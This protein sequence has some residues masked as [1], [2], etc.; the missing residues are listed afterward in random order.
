MVSK[1]LS[2][3]RSVSPFAVSSG[4]RLIMAAAAILLVCAACTLNIYSNRK[5]ARRHAAQ[6]EM[7]IAISIQGDVTRV[8]DELDRSIQSALR[9]MAAPGFGEMDA[10]LR[11]AVLFDG[12]L[13]VEGEVGTALIAD[14]S[15]QTIYDS[16]GVF[17]RKINVYDRDYFQAQMRQPDLGLFISRPVLSRIDQQ[18]VLV[19]VRRVNH[20]DGSFAGVVAVGLRLR[21]FQNLFAQLDI[22][23]QG[24]I[25]LI[26]AD[27]HLIARRPFREGDINRDMSRSDLFRHLSTDSSG[28]FDAVGSFDGLDRLYS[29]RKFENLPFVVCVGLP[30]REVYAE[31]LQSS[32][33]LGFVL[34]LLLAFTGSSLAWALWCELSRRGR[35]E[36]AARRLEHKYIDARAR[37]D[38]LFANS[39]DMMVVARSIAQGN[40]VF[41]AVNP[42]WEH[43]AG[44]PAKA[45]L[46]RCVHTCMSSE[47]A[48]CLL[49]AWEVCQRQ[50]RPLKRTF[51]TGDGRAKRSWEASIAPVFS[52]DG[53][54]HR[55]V[56][57][58]RDMTERQ[59]LEASL[60]QSQRM[61]AM[62]QLTAGVAHDFNNLLQGIIG[63]LE[64]LSEQP[65]PTQESR[66]YI[67]VARDAAESGANLVHRLLAFARKQPLQP[68]VL[69]P[70]QIVS[71]MS[72]LLRHTLGAR[73][74]LE[75]EIAEAPWAVRADGPQLQNCL[76]NLAINARDAMQAG[77]V[78]RLSV[79]NVDAETAKAAGL[80]SGEYT[81]FAVAD[82]GEGMSPETLE[83]ALEPFFTTKEE[84]KGT[85]LGLPMV[86]GFARQSGGDLRIESA[87]GQGTTVRLWLPRATETECDV[88]EA[89]SAVQLRAS[90]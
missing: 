84:G 10:V 1:N 50:R 54:I 61:E 46:G 7:N 63:A 8:I 15:G 5:S 24:T 89:D 16:R 30:E 45:A 73:I 42:V 31:W 21:Y 60:R 55:V 52:R 6:Q 12:L 40:F 74:R 65:L 53:Q 68:E 76:L 82:E 85:G 77:G 34:L 22:G 49:Q 43:I 18:W 57:V 62:G 2:I 32:A 36:F 64:V 67:H 14:E 27:Q 26:S 56:T 51:T 58:A 86:Q 88:D 44:M 28:I 35:A 37:L 19:L 11:H 83:R 87:P 47:L 17:P 20:A 29:Y 59:L 25:N 38:T 69:R 39:E 3:L 9:G 70:E 81:C 41:D 48:D 75:M 13:A 72:Q 66:Q 90:G 71:Q 23:R 33:V 4:P 79:A 78:I 80:Q